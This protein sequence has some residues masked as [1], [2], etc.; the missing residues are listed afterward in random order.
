[1]PGSTYLLTVYT[2]PDG[3]DVVTCIDGYDHRNVGPATSCR[4]EGLEA[5]EIYYYIVAVS[6]GWEMS[7][8]SNEIM[9]TTGQAPIYKLKVNA[10]QAR[11]AIDNGF[12]AAWEKMDVANDYILTVYTKEL[13]GHYTDGCDFTAGIDKLPAGWSANTGSSYANTAYSGKAIPAIRLGRN[14]DAVTTP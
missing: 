11:D 9:V 10:L 4:V 6:N 2:R 14:A 12:T 1:V 8:E 7:E 5:G 13:T 3:S